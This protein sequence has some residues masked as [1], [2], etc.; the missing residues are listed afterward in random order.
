MAGGSLKTTLSKSKRNA[1]PGDSGAAAWAG[2]AEQAV[3]LFL[4]HVG[5]AESRNRPLSARLDLD[6]DQRAAVPGTRSISAAPEGG[7]SCA[8]RL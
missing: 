2:G 3:A 5:E 4:V 8:P 7:R 1:L 6:E